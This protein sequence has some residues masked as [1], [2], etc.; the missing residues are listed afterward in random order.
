MPL[1][2]RPL[3]QNLETS[4]QTAAKLHSH[5]GIGPF[6]RASAREQRE[7]GHF[8]QGRMAKVFAKNLGRVQKS[9]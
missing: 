9:H 8:L 1:L 6:L 5:T 7:E 2:A 3:V 4:L